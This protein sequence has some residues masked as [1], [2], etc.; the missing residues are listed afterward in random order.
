MHRLLL[1]TYKELLQIFERHI[2]FLPKA[3]LL[4]ND[5]IDIILEEDRPISHTIQVLFKF[6]MHT[7]TTIHIYRQEELKKKL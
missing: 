3:A 5:I 2:I 4:D 6:C 7:Y 1:N